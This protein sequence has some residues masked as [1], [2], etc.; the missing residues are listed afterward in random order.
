VKN[1]FKYVF[2]Q[3][4]KKNRIFEI[5]KM[6]ENKEN[7]AL[8]DVE[9]VIKEKNPKLFKILPK[10]L[11]SYLKKIVHQDELNDE[12][13]KNKDK[14]GI[15]FAKAVIEDF[16]IKINIKNIEKLPKD[17]RYILASNHPLGGIDA[18]TLITAV[19]TKRQDMKFVVNDILMHL[20]NLKNIFLAVNKH[21]STTYDNI[22]KLEDVFAG[23][24]LVIIFPAGLVSRKRFGKIKDLEWKKTFIAKAKKHKRDIIPVFV[25][26]RN[27][28]FFYNLAKIRSKLGLKSN[29]EMLYLPDEMFKQK[30]KTINITFGDVIEYSTFDKSKN[31]AHWANYVKEKVYSL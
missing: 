7:K 25:D 17:G 24:E 28:N 5:I 10:F 21:G 18:L 29:L 2:L 31:D 3:V 23:D 20:T 19:G 30:N 16:N 27:S 15:D 4:A 13:E 9:K 1:E 11:I 8:I 22:K 6:L 26:G 12:V 14:F